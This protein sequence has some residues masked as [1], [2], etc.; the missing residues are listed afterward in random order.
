MRS[1]IARLIPASGY[2]NATTSPSTRD[3]FVSSHHKCPP[4]PALYVRDDRETPLERGGIARA[5][6]DDLPDGESEIFSANELD[7]Q[8]NQPVAPLA[9]FTLKRRLPAGRF[10]FHLC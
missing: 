3:A 10:P 8:A 2:Q 6:R 4:H 1:I 5:Y 7:M 9:H